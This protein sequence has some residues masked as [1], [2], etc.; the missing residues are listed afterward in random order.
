MINFRKTVEKLTKESVKELNEKLSTK[1]T[2]VEE[3]AIRYG[4]TK[5]LDFGIK[6]A[7]NF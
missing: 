6:N 1:L 4:I 7:K 2:S 5:G 3:T